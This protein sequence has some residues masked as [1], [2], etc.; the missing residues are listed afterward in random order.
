MCLLLARIGPCNGHFGPA[1]FVST[2]RILVFQDKPDMLVLKE[3][4]RSP[5]TNRAEP[6]RALQGSMRGQPAY[7]ILD[8]S[9][10]A[11]PEQLA[12]EPSIATA[13]Q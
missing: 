1:L 10:K 8:R 11:R 13:Y 9:G 6:R 5:P 4:E 7:R 2:D 12:W 3:E